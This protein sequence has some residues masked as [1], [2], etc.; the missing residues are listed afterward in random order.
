MYVCMYV[1]QLYG[2]DIPIDERTSF[3]I[4]RDEEYKKIRAVK[5]EEEEENLDH[6]LMPRADRENI[7]GKN[8]A[9][10]RRHRPLP[11]LKDIV[12]HPPSQVRVSRYV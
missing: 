7:L 1:F 3:E 9:T 2:S 10:G 4:E 6:F 12:H 5:F 11:R 8:F